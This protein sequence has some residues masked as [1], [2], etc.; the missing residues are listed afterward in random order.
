M[1]TVWDYFL[2]AYNCPLKEKIGIDPILGDNG[3]WLC[4]VRTLLQRP[5]CVI[6]SF[7]CA[8]L[9]ASHT[10]NACALILRLRHAP[11]QLCSTELMAQHL[12]DGLQ[13]CCPCDYLCMACILIV[14]EMM[15]L[16]V[17]WGD[18]LYMAGMVIIGEM[19][20]LQVERGDNL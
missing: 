15:C 20:C 10:L 5:G 2:P 13:G 16:Q 18:K 8:A 14:G 12:A 9:Q 3:K 11:Q 17:E 4:G 1:C 7:G 19:M 6:Y